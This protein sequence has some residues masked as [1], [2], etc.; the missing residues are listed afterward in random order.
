MWFDVKAERAKLQLNTNANPAKHANQSLPISSFSMFSRAPEADASQ[1]VC[2]T[3]PAHAGTDPIE[4]EKMKGAREYFEERAAIREYDGGQ[5]RSE[6]E[7]DALIEAARATGLKLID[8]R[9]VLAG[10]NET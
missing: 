1:S 8:L 7:A 3:L 2:A 5:P 9:A 4:P 6:A 10:K